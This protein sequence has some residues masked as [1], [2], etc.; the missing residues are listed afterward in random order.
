MPLCPFVLAV[1]CVCTVGFLPS[2]RSHQFHVLC[3]EKDSGGH[4]LNVLFIQSCGCATPV[5]KCSD[6]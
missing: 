5:Q 6:T 3:M 4:L 2:A 1:L